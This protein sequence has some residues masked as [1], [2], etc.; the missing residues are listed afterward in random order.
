MIKDPLLPVEYA[1]S[2][3]FLKESEYIG[4]PDLQMFPSIAGF[5]Q[6]SINHTNNAYFN[7]SLNK[8]F[9]F[10]FNRNIYIY[11]YIYINIYIY[12]YIYIY[13]YICVYVCKYIYLYSY[14][15]II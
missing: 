15:Y 9:M 4:T 13:I 2:D 8:Y 3:S 14:M 7:S 6:L 5:L 11:I 12:L 1:G 10:Y